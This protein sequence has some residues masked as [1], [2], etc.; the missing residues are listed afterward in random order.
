MNGTFETKNESAFFETLRIDGEQ[1]QTEFSDKIDFTGL[2]SLYENELYRFAYFYLHNKEDAED[3]VQ[4]AA[5]RAFKGVSSLKNKDAFKNWMFTILFRCCK[6]K[7]AGIIRQRE[8][9][10]ID[11]YSLQTPDSTEDLTQAIALRNEINNLGKRERAMIWLSVTAGYKSR[12]I[13]KIMNLSEGTVR[14][15]LSRA[16]AKLRERMDF[17][18]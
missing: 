5:L 16:F 15:S 13:A 8:Q 11:E 12:E 14:S 4:E 3:A 6:S 7:I 9:V 10:S 1:K 17:E 2:Y 18:L